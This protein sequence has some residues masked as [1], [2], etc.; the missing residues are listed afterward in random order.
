MYL[1]LGNKLFE[2]LPND[3]ILHL[4]LLG[5]VFAVSISFG[6]LRFRDDA[7]I[8]LGTFLPRS[9][10]R[11][12]TTKQVTPD[13]E[14]GTARFGPLKINKTFLFCFVENEKN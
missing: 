11:I 10:G 13:K 5:R 14:S 1:V 8:L 12:I 9:W 7:G 4:D 3:I 6:L 2:I